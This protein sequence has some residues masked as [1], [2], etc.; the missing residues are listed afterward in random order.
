MRSEIQKFMKVTR[1]RIFEK[2]WKLGGEIIWTKAYD[3][4]EVMA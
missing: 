3:T 1:V 2:L 4:K